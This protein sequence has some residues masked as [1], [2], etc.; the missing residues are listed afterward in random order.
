MF[1]RT[2]QRLVEK[3]VDLFP[4]GWGHDIH[5][6]LLKRHSC[7][8]V[9]RAE[10]IPSLLTAWLSTNLAMQPGFCQRPFPHDGARRY[11]ENLCCLFDAETSKETELDDLTFAWVQR[12]QAVECVIDGHHFGGTFRRN[13]SDFL[14]RHILNAP[15]AL[16]V[17]TVASVVNQDAA[18]QLGGNAKELRAVL[19]A[20]PSLIDEAEI[21]FVDQ[22]RGLQRWP[23]DSFRI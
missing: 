14:Q 4:L 7:R 15:S 17:A 9:S 8:A 16:E 6:D 5:L 18:H 19:P 22:H 2:L 21:G 3:L 11:F 20:H 1:R 10:N 23:G 13:H 12:G